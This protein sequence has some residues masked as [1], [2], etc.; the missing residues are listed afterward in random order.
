MEDEKQAARDRAM[1]TRLIKRSDPEFMQYR[2]EYVRAWR[3]ANPEYAREYR[4]KNAGRLKHAQR[5]RTLRAYG[6]TEEMFDRML[7]E[8]NGQCAICGGQ[9]SGRWKTLFVDHDHKTGAVRGLLCHLCNAAL[10]RVD[11][12]RAEI[13]VYLTRY[14]CEST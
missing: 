4:Q 10:E 3:K 9:P 14:T 6:L 13:D 8:Q 12:Y 2:A 5:Q 11:N 1:R 7:A